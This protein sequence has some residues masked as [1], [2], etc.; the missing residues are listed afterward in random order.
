MTLPSPGRGFMEATALLQGYHR[1]RERRFCLSGC[2]QAI[3]AAPLCG[4]CVVLLL[5]HERVRYEYV[6]KLMNAWGRLVYIRSKC[7]LRGD[8]V[9]LVKHSV[10]PIRIGMRVTCVAG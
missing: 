6:R 4:Q 3:G 7:S 5:D 2:D 8:C 9:L 1:S 10:D